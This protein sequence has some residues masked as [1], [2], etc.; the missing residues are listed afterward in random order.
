[1]GSIS[2]ISMKS[3]ILKEKLKINPHS[4]KEII[5]KIDLLEKEMFLNMIKFDEIMSK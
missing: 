5:K 1:M 3:K 4:V 2:E